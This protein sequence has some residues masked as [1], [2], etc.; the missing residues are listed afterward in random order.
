[1]DSN[2]NNLSNKILEQLYT[3]GSGYDILRYIALPELLGAEKKT[4]LYFMG[5]NIARKFSFE[6]IE[7]IQHAFRQLGWGNLELV[8][9]RSKSYTF[10]LMADAVVYRIRA[11][12]ETE[13]RLESGFL[14][15]SMQQIERTECECVEKVNKRLHQV[16]LKVIL[17]I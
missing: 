10:H 7:E 4:I 5:K 11:P 8:K 2:L 16:E 9:E 17:T 3:D 1:M 14:A 13:F 6:T 12:F 15:E